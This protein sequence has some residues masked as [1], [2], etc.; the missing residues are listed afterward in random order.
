MVLDVAGSNPV[1][2]PSK[3]LSAIHAAKAFFVQLR[4]GRSRP[5]STDATVCG[6][7]IGRDQMKRRPQQNVNVFGQAD[8]GLMKTWGCMAIGG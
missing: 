2:H 8:P 4:T 7:G 3:A 1:S 5:H 6:T